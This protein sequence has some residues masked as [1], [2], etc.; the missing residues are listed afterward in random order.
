[1]RVLVAGSS[2]LVGS[3]LL[4]EFL[5]SKYEV[6]GISSKDLDLTDEKSTIKWFKD[7][8]P[9][10]VVIDSAAKVGGILANS[11][12]P[13]EFLSLNLKIQNNLMAACNLTN[14]SKFIFLGSSCIYPRNAKQPIKEEYLLS[15][16]LEETNSAYAI[17][18]IAGIEMVR[19]YRKEYGRNW[20]SLMPTNIYGPKDNF[21]VDSSHVVPAL[22][23]K[24]I[25]A[26]QEDKSEVTLWGTGSPLREFL[27]SDDLASAIHFAMKN[28][29]GDE[30][31]NVGTGQ[32]ISI[33]DLARLIA[34]EVKYN[35]VIKWDSSKPDGTPRKLL[36]SS[37]LNKLGWMPSTTLRDGIRLTIS[38]FEKAMEQKEV[39]V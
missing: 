28:Y 7:Q 9:F 29:D 2:G 15:G 10:D 23:R 17:A 34:E 13:V 8:K 14:V 22:I 12:N 16:T 3:A 27:F 11:E 26:R 19:A 1:M 33:A 31:L 35:G 24:F 37:K 5:S 32:E 6:V 21:N 38:W 36:D 20:I 18:K 4:R 30:H 39:R 25:N